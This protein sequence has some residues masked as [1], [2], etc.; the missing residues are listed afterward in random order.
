MYR[1]MDKAALDAA[2]N[3]GAAVRNS[4]QIVAG[5]EARSAKLRAAHPDGMDLRYGPDER[6]AIFA[7][8]AALC[9]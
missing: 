5:W 4:A 1:G 6:S 7:M 8:N 3:N 9:R 2:Y